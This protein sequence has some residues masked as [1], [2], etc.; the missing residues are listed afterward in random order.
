[1]TVAPATGP[2]LTQAVAYVH[3]RASSPSTFPSF[4][5][6]PRTIGGGDA[7][8]PSG[9]TS[10][11]PGRSSWP[12]STEAPERTGFYDLRLDEAVR[13]QA[14]LATEAGIDGFMYYH[15]WFAGVELLSG[16]IRSRLA[17]DV[18]L[19]FCLMWANEN[20]TRRWDGRESDVLMGQRYEEVSAAR[21]LV[22]V[23]PILHDP[24]YMKIDG[25]PIVAVYRPGQIP[26]VAHI[27]EA[28]RKT[29]HREGLGD[30]FVM[31]VDVA[32]EFHGLE[33]GMAT[34]GL[35][36]SLD[37]RPTTPGGPGCHASRSAS[38]LASE[39]TS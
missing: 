11:P 4:T 22:D 34:A 10:P 32:R 9:A 18:E 16:P 3:G 17:A 8:S 31:N 27:V 14:S 5:R 37:F 39:A 36:G 33:G 38:A 26:D 19:P 15:Y 29:A 25:R 28:W 23:L 7:A 30:L 35:D 20:W 2:G 6:S 21:F 13:L 24:R 1:M 12:S